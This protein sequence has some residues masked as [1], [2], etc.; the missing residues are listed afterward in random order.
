VITIKLMFGIDQIPKYISTVD[1]RCQ[2]ITFEFEKYN[3]KMI[4]ID[5]KLTIIK[6]KILHINIL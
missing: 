3:H 1:H 4:D 6:E 2:V 5:Q